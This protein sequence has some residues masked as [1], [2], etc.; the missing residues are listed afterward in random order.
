[1]YIVYKVNCVFKKNEIDTNEINIEI[2]NVF[3]KIGEARHY[4]NN[5]DYVVVNKK[6][7]VISRIVEEKPTDKDDDGFYLVKNDIV[8]NRVDIYKKKT[9]LIEGYLYNSYEIKIEKLVFFEIK[10]VDRAMDEKQITEV[11]DTLQKNIS[12]NFNKLCFYPKNLLQ[13]LKQKL[14]EK[15]LKLENKEQ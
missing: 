13:E 4:I 2:D 9:K 1:M 5:F 15:K 11:C 3:S 6:K 7:C 8:E 10:Y 12:P 14:D